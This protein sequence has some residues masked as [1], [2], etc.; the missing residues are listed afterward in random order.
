MGLVKHV[1]RLLG[2]RYILVGTNYA[3]KWVEAQALHTNTKITIAKFLYEISL[4]DL[5]VH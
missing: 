4:Q 2:N 3:T 5:N 1:S